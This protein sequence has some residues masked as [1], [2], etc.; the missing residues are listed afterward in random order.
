MFSLWIYIY[1]YISPFAFKGSSPGGVGL[2]RIN[3]RI[4]GT[5]LLTAV[6]GMFFQLL[7]WTISSVTWWDPTGGDDTGG[8]IWWWLVFFFGYVSSGCVVRD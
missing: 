3:G 4:N 1:I 7:G 8:W 2:G 6:C 5:R